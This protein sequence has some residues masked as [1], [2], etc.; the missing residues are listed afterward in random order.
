MTDQEYKLFADDAVEVLNTLNQKLNEEFG[1]GGYER[2]DYQQ[3]SGEF[4]FSHQGVPKVA[5]QVQIVGSYSSAGRSWLWA[6]ANASILEGGREQ[7]PKVRD[8]GIAEGIG[9]LREAKWTAE[10][11]DGWEMTAVAVKLLGAKGAYRCPVRTGFLYVIFMD[12]KKIAGD[13]APGES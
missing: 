2:W 7:V 13:A 4:V 8:F 9:K 3:E 11:S 6:W 12:V 5:A 10:E 1:I